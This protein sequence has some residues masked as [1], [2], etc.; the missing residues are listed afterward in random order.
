MLS[1]IA[2]LL[3]FQTQ[4]A[5]PP[6]PEEA[7]RLELEEQAAASRAE[8]AQSAA[9]GYELVAFRRPSLLFVHAKT[10]KA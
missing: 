4:P 1:I 3:I 2:A 6:D 5:S 8:A 9:H 10:E 7:A